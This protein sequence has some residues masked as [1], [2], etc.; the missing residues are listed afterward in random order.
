[1]RDLFEKAPAPEYKL[2]FDM[3]I[4]SLVVRLTFSAQPSL[5][6]FSDHAGAAVENA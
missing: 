3:F 6:L 2:A 5:I 1:V 4:S